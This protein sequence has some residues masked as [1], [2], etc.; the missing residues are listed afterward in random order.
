MI[1]DEEV[2]MFSTLENAEEIAIKRMVVHLRR[3]VWED[4][5]RRV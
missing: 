1:W 5:Q 4:A 3:V 2:E